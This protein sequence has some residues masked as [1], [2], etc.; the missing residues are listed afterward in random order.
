MFITLGTGSEYV[1]QNLNTYLFIADLQTIANK[2]EKNG[3]GY[4]LN[5]S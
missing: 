4:E 3:S 1:F 2:P 5:S